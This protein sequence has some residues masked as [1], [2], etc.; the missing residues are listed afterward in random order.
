MV[1]SDLRKAFQFPKADKDY[2]PLYERSMWG[3]VGIVTTR[4]N[5]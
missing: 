2:T 3:E 1:I 4:V 5:D